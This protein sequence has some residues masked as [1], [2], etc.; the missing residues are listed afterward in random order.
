M[1]VPKLARRRRVGTKTFTKRRPPATEQCNNN[2]NADRWFNYSFNNSYD[3]PPLYSTHHFND[4]DDYDNDQ[5]NSNS[6][7][8]E[9]IP[10]SRR[11]YVEARRREAKLLGQKKRRL[12]RGRG[13]EEDS[14]RTPKSTRRKVYVIKDISNVPLTTKTRSKQA[15]PIAEEVSRVLNKIPPH[16]NPT[17]S[18]SIIDV[19]PTRK[20]ATEAKGVQMGSAGDGTTTDDHYSSEDNPSTLRSP[21][22][23]DAESPR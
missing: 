10:R 6:T 22:T 8:F 5:F 16:R 7:A 12:G 17:K 15:N 4:V 14:P 13:R 23:D 11:Q 20:I 9:P 19:M 3:D 18:K 2:S 21:S 1:L